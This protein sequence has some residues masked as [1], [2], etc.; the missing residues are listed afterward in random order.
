MMKYY[1]EAETFLKSM[2]IKY[3]ILEKDKLDS[4]HHYIGVGE[5]E[6]AFEGTMLCYMEQAIVFTEGEKEKI[7]KYADILKLN[8]ESVLENEFWKKLNRFLFP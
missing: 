4:I 3:E 2:L 1:Y 8:E 7:I 6:I 5:L